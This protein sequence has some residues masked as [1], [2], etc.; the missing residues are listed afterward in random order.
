MPTDRDQWDAYAVTR[1]T[2]DDATAN[3]YMAQGLDPAGAAYVHSLN[4]AV[5]QIGSRQ[6]P[7]TAA[8]LPVAP[9]SARSSGGVLRKVGKLLLACLLAFVVVWLVPVD[10]ALK[11]AARAVSGVS[12][13]TLTDPALYETSMPTEFARRLE[14]NLVLA[15][16]AIA[17]F[18]SASSTAA[19]A[20][21]AAADAFWAATVQGYRYQPD[22]FEKANRASNTAQEVLTRLQERTSR[23]LPASDFGHA[24]VATSGDFIDFEHL[25]AHQDSVHRRFPDNPVIRDRARQLSGWRFTAA[26]WLDMIGDMYFL[27]A[28]QAD[29]AVQ[30]GVAH[31][32]SKMRRS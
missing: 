18:E 9:T 3:R 6:G 1:V 28:R 19:R 2:M 7:R 20:P 24:I 15:A 5:D 25:K 27:L 8:Y 29:R 32:E 14:E 10:K 30:A 13:Y 11:W 26:F 31:V 16:P 22:H 4:T 12:A 17:A 23:T 21:S